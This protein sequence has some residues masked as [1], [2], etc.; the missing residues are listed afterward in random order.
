MRDGEIMAVI[1]PSRS[2][3]LNLRSRLKLATSGYNVLKKKRDS[4]I[5]EF[6]GLLKHMNY[7]NTELESKYR[8]A[9]YAINIARAVEGTQQIRSVSFGPKAQINLDIQPRKIMN[10]SVP[11]ISFNKN[12]GDFYDRGYGLIGTSGY[13]DDAYES[14]GNVIEQVLA[15]AETEIAMKRLL[16]EIDKTKRKV[17]ALEFK[18]IPELEVGIKYVRQRLEEMERENLFRLKR[19]KSKKTKKH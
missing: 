13:V 16:V 2:E 11:K 15:I 12:S 9:L 10:V 18:I 5:R 3:L 1:K 6:F 7:S 17:N 8:E 14:Y 4:L 19:L